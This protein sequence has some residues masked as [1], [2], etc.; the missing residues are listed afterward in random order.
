MRACEA[1]KRAQKRT[2]IDE[3]RR[4]FLRSNFFES[5]KQPQFWLLD[6][7]IQ[8]ATIDHELNSDSHSRRFIVIKKGRQTGRTIRSCGVAPA[9][10][11]AS[12]SRCLPPSRTAG[13]APGSSLRVA[14]SR[15]A[16]GAEF[17]S[18]SGFRPDRSALHSDMRLS[19]RTS[20]SAAATEPLHAPMNSPKER[21]SPCLAGFPSIVF[22][23]A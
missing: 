15:G 17:I 22:I 16:S 3:S 19:K 2:L 10:K 8:Q 20:G 6:A 5:K 13:P 23:N 21:G 1:S 9:P 18:V 14:G 7:L 4:K 12:P 11:K